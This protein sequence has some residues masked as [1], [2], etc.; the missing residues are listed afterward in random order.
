[1]RHLVEVRISIGRPV[2]DVWGLARDPKAWPPMPGAPFELQISAAEP[3][4]RLVYSIT[5]GLPVREHCGELVLA[6]TPTGG[7]EL[8][9]RESFRPRIWGTGG[10]LRGRRERVLVDT[11]RTWER[12]SQ[13]SASGPTT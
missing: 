5:D 6:E 11:S 12:V 10:Y 4:R 3:P 8:V 13:G 9:F 7:T 2:A 1:M